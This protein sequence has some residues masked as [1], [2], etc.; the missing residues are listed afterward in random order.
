MKTQLP[1][2]A[3]VTKGISNA[4]AFVLALSLALSLGCLVMFVN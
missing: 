1:S 2:P 3:K 4:I